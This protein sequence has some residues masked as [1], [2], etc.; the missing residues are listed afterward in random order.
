MNLSEQTAADVDSAATLSIW[1]TVERELSAAPAAAAPNLW[2]ALKTALDIGQ[3]IPTRADGVVVRELQDR[4]GQYFVLKNPR[5]RTYLRLT[6]REFWLWEQ[7]DGARNIQDLV[8]AFSVKHHAFALTMIVGM[9]EQ[10]SAKNMLRDTPQH[11]FTDVSRAL[12]ERSVALR[13]TWLAR[14]V[15][16]RPWAIGDLDR[17]ITRLHQR[18]GW[19]F[20]TLPAQIFYIVVSLVGGFLFI[21][22]LGDPRYTFGG[23]ALGVEIVALW[24]AAIFPVLIHEL[25]HALT[26]K[27]YGRDV[28]YGGLMLYLGMPAAFVDTSDIWME[29]RRARL[30]V[31]W[32]GPYTGL[33]IGG[34]GAIALWLNPNLTFAPFLFQMTV[35]AMFTAVLNLNPL[36]KLDGYYLLSDWLEISQ[37]RERSFAFVQHNLLSKLTR[38]ERF[39]RDEIIF[40]AFGALSAVWTVYVILVSVMVWNVRIVS[41]AQSLA[42]GTGDPIALFVNGILVL[43]ALSFLAL[44]GFEMYQFGRALL[45]R[46]RRANIF[47]D[48]LRLAVTSAVSAL[49]LT[50][51]PPLLAP[52][53]AAEINLLMGLVGFTAF[54]CLSL[55]VAGEMR[56]AVFAPT[57]MAFAFG[58]TSMAI[59]LAFRNLSALDASIARWLNVAGV[60][61]LILGIVLGWRLFA[62][63][64]GSWRAKSIALMGLGLVSLLTAL[65][66]ENRAPLA[67]YTFAGIVLAGGILH[68]KMFRLPPVQA[69]TTPDLA[70]GTE[71]QLTHACAQLVET[72][73]AQLRAAYGSGAAQR[74]QTEFNRAAQTR[75]LELT[76]AD[77]R[78]T[79]ARATGAEQALSD[80]SEMLAAALDILLQSVERAAG[81][82]F[83]HDALTRSLDALDWEQRELVGEHILPHVS[84]RV[85]LDGELAATSRDMLAMLEGTPLFAGFTLEER[86]RL[87]GK[88]RVQYLKRGQVLLHQGDSADAIYFVRWGRLQERKR[89]AHGF[90][91]TLREIGSGEYLGENDLL[92][93]KP[94]PTTLRALTPVQLFA[95]NHQDLKHLA[96]AD[97]HANKLDHALRRVNLLRDIPLFAEFEPREL[98]RV[99]AQMRALSFAPNQSIIEQGEPGDKFF[100][101]ESGVV[102][103]RQQLPDG[104]CA[105]QA[106]LEAGEY[107]GEIELLLNAPSPAA[108][109]AAAPTE[110]LALDARAFEQLARG[111]QRLKRELE[112]SATRRLRSTRR[113]GRL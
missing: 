63:L 65:L 84:W 21:R 96:R 52:Q 75:A 78:L 59:A 67:L 24:L 99:V 97:S 88:L 5:T 100:V 3:A 93:D 82:R 2:Q 94:H 26:T 7:L 69:D 11:V 17:H 64:G 105:E 14:V 29:G 103:A 9:V 79:I 44:L 80:L 19:V 53:W 61:M 8:V 13:T 30:A 48:P 109:V 110:L 85:G 6:P 86:K 46:A 83:A 91:S 35:V 77:A 57:W 38:R 102:A 111:S 104:T 32:A 12:A 98:Q 27:H 62:G 66:V 22:L 34:L 71:E 51:I 55:V 89:D 41:S 107:F 73:M 70:L 47:S 43:L 15:L 49:A 1:Q 50:F 39:S 58:G 54:A 76:L 40:V 81:E 45:A 101:I 56:G 25:G 31:T 18:G 113:R 20:Y 90:E 87:T 16:T 92:A 28:P 23:K 4:S 10:L 72:M 42:S 36:I 68:W 33:V 95:L 106:R 60:S 108:Y 112:R 74:V 37:L